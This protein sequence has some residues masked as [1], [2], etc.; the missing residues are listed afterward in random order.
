MLKKLFFFSICCL[1][2]LTASSQCARHLIE[3][4]GNAKDYPGSNILVIFDSTHVD[5]QPTGLSYVNTHRLYKILTRDGAKRM[6][7]FK[8]DY[9]PLSAYVEIKKVVVHKKNGGKKEVDV[10][11]VLDYPAPARM[12]YWG[13]SEKMIEI[14]RLEP[15]DAVDVFL[16]KKGFTYALLQGEDDDERYIPPMRGHFYDIVEFWSSDPLLVKSYVVKA[17]KDKPM[18]YE[19]YNGE[20]QSSVVFRG[21][22]IIYSFVKKDILPLKRE[23]GMVAW[24]DVAPKLLMSTSPDWYA[25]SL[26]FYGVNEDYGSFESTPEIDKKVNEILYGA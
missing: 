12:I 4:T 16:F 1:I 13:A 8:Y 7:A 2:G 17:P 18:Q 9:D 3:N 19:F 26:W 22:K 25:K 20:V 14:G 6:A 24:S 21:D 15:G 11:K 5:V 23:P 10:S